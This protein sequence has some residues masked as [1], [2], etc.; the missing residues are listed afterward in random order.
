MEDG[1]HP[2][3]AAA[4]FEDSHPVTGAPRVRDHFRARRT[5]AVVR[6]WFAVR[7]PECNKIALFDL[8]Q[9]AGRLGFRGR[10]WW[11]LPGPGAPAVDRDRLARPGILVLDQALR[12]VRNLHG[13]SSN[14]PHQRISWARSGISLPGPHPRGDP[15]EKRLPSNQLPRRRQTIRVVA[16]PELITT[17][18]RILLVHIQHVRTSGDPTTSSA[19]G[20]RQGAVF[21]VAVVDRLRFRTPVGRHCQRI[22]GVHL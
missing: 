9:L 8:E 7:W 21:A 11:Y 6:G 4:L 14:R 5:F 12:H 19:Q 22:L 1:S 2:R 16:L 15:L 10:G 20:S 3:P 17:G 13:V 18:A